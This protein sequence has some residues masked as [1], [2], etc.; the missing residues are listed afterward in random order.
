MIATKSEAQVRDTFLRE[1]FEKI[2]KMR[3]EQFSILE[4]TENRGKAFIFSFVISVNASGKADYIKYNSTPEMSNL[5]EGSKFEEKIKE[6]DFIKYKNK[7]LWLPF[8]LKNMNDNTIKNGLNKEFELQWQNL[9]PP[10]LVNFAP[11]RA[12]VLFSPEIYSYKTLP[13]KIIN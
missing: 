5:F 4:K 9:I 8:L 12:I 7:K 1:K 2:L 10:E 3:P 11:N 6:I 13:S